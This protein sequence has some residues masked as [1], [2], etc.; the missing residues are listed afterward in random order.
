MEKEEEEK[1]PWKIRKRREQVVE[2]DEVIGA[3]YEYSST[4]NRS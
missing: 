2:E 4:V 3:G 1:K